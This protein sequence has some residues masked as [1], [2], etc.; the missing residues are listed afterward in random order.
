V[1]RQREARE[2]PDFLRVIVLEMNMRKSGKLNKTGAGR[3]RFALPAR[4]TR[5]ERHD[6]EMDNAAEKLP[7]RWTEWAMD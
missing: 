7:R 1:P 6:V 4:V 2:N 3:A 5:P